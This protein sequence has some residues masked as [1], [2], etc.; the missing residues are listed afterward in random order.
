MQLSK[1]AFYSARITKTTN[2]SAQVKR[3]VNTSVTRS[4]QGADEER[5]CVGMCSLG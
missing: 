1:I 5:A 2:Q 4:L 3:L